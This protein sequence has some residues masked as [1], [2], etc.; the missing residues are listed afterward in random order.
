MFKW[1]CLKICRIYVFKLKSNFR[2]KKSSNFTFCH[3][4]TMHVEKALE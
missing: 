1:F 3:N 4:I 2:Q